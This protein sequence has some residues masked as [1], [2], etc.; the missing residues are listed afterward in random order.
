MDKI[1]LSKTTLSQLSKTALFTLLY[2]AWFIGLVGLRTEHIVMY[3]LL[4]LSYF[5]T[6]TS[7]Q[8]I[9]AF[10]AFVIY[11]VLY[12]SMRIWPNYKVNPIH[13]VEPYLLEK[14]LFGITSGSIL[15]TLN[16]Y[17]ALHHHSFIDVLAGIFYLCWV[18]VPLA[19]AMYLYFTDLPTSFKFSYCFLFIN[20]IGFVL[21]YIYPAAPPWYVA[22]YG[23]EPHYHVGGGVG[24]LKYFDSITGTSIFETMY[25]KNANVFA[26]M[27]SMHSTYPIIVLYYGLKKRLGS[28][29]IIFAILSLGIW[30]TAVYS[31]HHYVIDVLAGISIAIFGI[32]IFE[33]YLS[34]KI[35]QFYLWAF[36]NSKD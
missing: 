16:E 29:N 7:R 14:Q 1:L 11:W 24:G 18:P 20:I 31:G 6:K 26:A 33:K 23:F 36:E 25:K 35:H 22:Q 12:D 34:Q 15:L 27:P 9:L 28:I 8:F 17:F 3:A 13:I 5:G 2:F 21:Y 19:F 10:A 32:F 30:F 4:I